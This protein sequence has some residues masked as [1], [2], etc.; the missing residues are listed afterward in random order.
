[1]SEQEKIVEKKINTL[2]K[3]IKILEKNLPNYTEDFDKRRVSA[4]IYS[5]KEQVLK[6]RLWKE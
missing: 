6:L 1:M 3:E 2:E 4:I 5:K